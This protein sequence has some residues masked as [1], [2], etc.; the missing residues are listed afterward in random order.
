MC[1]TLSQYLS[2]YMPIETAQSL[3]K[4]YPNNPC[5]EMLETGIPN[6]SVY[7]KLAVA[8]QS[9][10]PAKL[11]HIDMNRGGTWPSINRLLDNF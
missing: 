5:V 4:L 10:L 6:A 3:L 11:P 8:L 7:E 2:I 9:G 1:I